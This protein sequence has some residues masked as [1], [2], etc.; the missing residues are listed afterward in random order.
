[1]E[2]GVK[3]VVFTTGIADSVPVTFSVILAPEGIAIPPSPPLP[4]NPC[5]VTFPGKTAA[6]IDN[7]PTIT[8]III[9]TF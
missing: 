8:N 5:A 4:K 3:P 2:L 7:S 6:A 9:T 1:M